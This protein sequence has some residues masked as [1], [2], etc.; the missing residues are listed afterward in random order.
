[1]KYSM[2]FSEENEMYRKDFEKVG[3]KGVLGI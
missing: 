2:W 3:V 1:M